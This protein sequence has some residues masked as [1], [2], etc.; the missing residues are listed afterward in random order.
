M[1]RVK[2]NNRSF[3]LI[4]HAVRCGMGYQGR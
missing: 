4:V 3:A 2:R 1:E